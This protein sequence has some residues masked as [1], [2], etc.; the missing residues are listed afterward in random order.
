MTDDHSFVRRWSRRKAAARP[1]AAPEAADQDTTATEAQIEAVPDHGG[2]DEA[3][4]E[5]AGGAEPLPDIETLDEDSDFRPFMRD[6]VPDNLRQLA[7]RKLWRTKPVLANLDGLVDYGEDFTDSSVVRTALQTAYRVGKGLLADDEAAA[8]A[9]RSEEGEGAIPTGDE[10][11]PGKPAGAAEPQP[12]GAR[13][14]D[15][16]SKGPQHAQA[17][18]PKD[19]PKDDPART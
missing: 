2:T 14:G 1:D 11:M 17:S 9:E 8:D 18:N 4:V 6:G 13:P 19:D 7:L 10:A 5:D 16:D 12:A 3:A 15:G